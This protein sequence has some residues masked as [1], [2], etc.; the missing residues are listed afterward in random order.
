MGFSFKDPIDPLRPLLFRIDAFK[1]FV[2]GKSVGRCVS[3]RV[4][5][6]DHSQNNP[7]HPGAN[8]L[9]PA[10]TLAGAIPILLGDNKED[11]WFTRAVVEQ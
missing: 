3:E 4:R 7:S 5:A 1:P 6:H 2:T 9:P 10:F 11:L 8:A